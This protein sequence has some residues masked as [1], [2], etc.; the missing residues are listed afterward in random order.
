MI[1]SGGG[2]ILAD[3]YSAPLAAWQG[4]CFCIE[5]QPGIAARMKEQL[6]DVARTFRQP[7]IAWAEVPSTV[8][9]G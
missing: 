3:W 6:A 8:Y 2:R 7:A 5:I 4:H 1:V 9:L